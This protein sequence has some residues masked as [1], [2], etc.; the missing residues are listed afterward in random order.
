MD[1]EKRKT[2]HRKTEYTGEIDQVGFT[3]SSPLTRVYKKSF[4]IL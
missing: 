1:T 4:R 2:K 3:G